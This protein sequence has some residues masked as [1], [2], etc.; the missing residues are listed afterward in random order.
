MRDV[1]PETYRLIGVSKRLG[2]AARAA[3]IEAIRLDVQ[4][5]PRRLVEQAV[6][7]AERKKAA[8]DKTRTTNK[9]EFRP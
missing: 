4:E 5:A 8:D 6:A 3:E 9:G 7:D 1:Y 2:N